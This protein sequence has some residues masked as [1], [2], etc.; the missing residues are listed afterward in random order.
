MKIGV[1]IRTWRESQKMGLRTMSA[2]IGISH[3]TLA[4]IERDEDVD[5]A[6]LIKLIIWLFL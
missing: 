3:G 2:Q 6:T 4:R 5:G 1:L